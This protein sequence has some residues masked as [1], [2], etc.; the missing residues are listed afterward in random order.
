MKFLAK[1]VIGP[2]LQPVDDIGLEALRN[3]KGE[4]FMVEIKMPRNIGHHR[5]YF[6]LLSII[7]ANQER[8]KTVKHLDRAMRLTCGVVELTDLPS[9][10]IN[11]SPGSLSFASMGQPEFNIFYDNAI[12][13][14]VKHFLPGVMSPICGRK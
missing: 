1:K 13:M 3:T 2:R 4:T 11:T 12:D 10:K 14:V 7:L 9:G 6:A 5:K 8:Y